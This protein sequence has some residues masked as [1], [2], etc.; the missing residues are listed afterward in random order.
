MSLLGLRKPTSGES[1]SV[2]KP[3]Y[4]PA[5]RKAFACGS[6][7]F[8]KIAVFM[9][10]LPKSLTRSLTSAKGTSRSINARPSRFSSKPTLR[11]PC[12]LLT[13]FQN[14]LSSILPAP[15]KGIS[16]AQICDRTFLLMPSSFVKSSVTA[17]LLSCNTPPASKITVSILV[18][19]AGVEPATLSLGR[20]CSIQLSYQ[21]EQPPLYCSM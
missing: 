20:I 8:D 17:E 11:N 2:S 10:I 16:S 18:P 7:V 3:S 15:S 4:K 9:P 6:I 14:S 13:S 19:Q 1:R 5:S 21:G 12:F